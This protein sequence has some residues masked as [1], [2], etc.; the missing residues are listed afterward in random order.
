[1]LM[2]ANRIKL[3]KDVSINYYQRETSIV[4]T[5]NVKKAFSKLEVIQHIRDENPIR[6][7]R[8][9]S[10]TGSFFPSRSDTTACVRK[11]IPGQARCADRF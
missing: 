11:R 10:I 2:L 3:L 1:M 9:S 8:S 4:H 6:N 5:M 7:I